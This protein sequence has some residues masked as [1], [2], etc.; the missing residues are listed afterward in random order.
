MLTYF[1]ALNTLASQA[2]LRACALLGLVHGRSRVETFKAV[3]AGLAQR[4][5]VYRVRF[6][7]IPASLAL[8]Q[9]GSIYSPRTPR[10]PSSTADLS[11]METRGSWERT[12][13]VL[14]ITLRAALTPKAL[15]PTAL[16][17]RLTPRLTPCWLPVA[18]QFKEN[19]HETHVVQC[20][21]RRG[22]A[23]SHR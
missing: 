5:V 4:A 17:N 3:P 11:I 22:N 2:A 7:P 9:V 15:M 16:T 10:S 20:H 8:G 12:A 23:R 21:T 19:R 6:E 13:V 14:A 1:I 18:A